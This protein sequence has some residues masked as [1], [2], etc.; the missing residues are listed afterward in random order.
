[1]V[2]MGVRAPLSGESIDLEDKDLVR[3]LTAIVITDNFEYQLTPAY[4]GV[5]VNYLS[6]SSYTRRKEFLQ[7]S[8]KFYHRSQYDTCLVKQ[9]EHMYLYSFKRFLRAKQEEDYGM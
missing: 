8:P 2:A 1:M 5:E 6:M 9:P 7:C 4:H 3:L